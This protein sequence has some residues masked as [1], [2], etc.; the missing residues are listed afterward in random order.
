MTRAKLVAVDE[1]HLMS[2]R[3]FRE[4]VHPV[5]QV[6]DGIPDFLPLVKAETTT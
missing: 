3:P 1:H 6:V 2:E 4:G 5:F